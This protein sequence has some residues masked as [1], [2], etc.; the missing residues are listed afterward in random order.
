M[1]INNYTPLYVTYR[2]SNCGNIVIVAHIVHENNIAT[3][4]DT[5]VWQGSSN[6]FDDKL[7][8]K[9]EIKPN[10]KIKKIYAEREKG[11]YRSAEFDCKCD[12]CGFREPWSRM[13]YYNYDVIAGSILPLGILIT[14]ISFPVGIWVLSSEAV[15]CFARYLHRY[16]IEKKIKKMPISSLPY[17]SLTPEDA[18]RISIEKYN[19]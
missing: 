4:G 10:E 1:H 7:R 15:Y 8:G 12:C 5:I 2:C 19:N 14:I 3:N 11:I 16:L 9:T 18:V 6:D 17:L 13:C